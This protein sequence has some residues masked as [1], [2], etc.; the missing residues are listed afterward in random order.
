MKIARET[1]YAIRCL[2]FMARRPFD[3]HTAGEIAG[4]QGIP[5]TFLAKILQKLVRAGILASAR[6][7]GGGFRLLRRPQDVTLL[8]AIEAVEGSLAP[9]TCLVEGRHCSRVARCAAHPVWREIQRDMAGTLARY[10]IQ[11][12]MESERKSTAATRG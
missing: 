11:S 8:D 5:P 7:V 6:G 12:M 10:S 1:D 9:N 3:I 4:A 2:L